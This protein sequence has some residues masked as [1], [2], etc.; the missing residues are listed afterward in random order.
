MLTSVAQDLNRSF[1]HGRNLILE[2]LPLLFRKLLSVIKG[3]LIIAAVSLTTG[4]LSYASHSGAECYLKGHRIYVPDG[5]NYPRQAWAGWGITC[6][7]ATPEMQRDQDQ[8]ERTL[9]SGRLSG[10]AG[11]CGNTLEDA[12]VLSSMWLATG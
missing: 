10:A 2:C 8:L 11:G 12:T 1:P 9:A 4:N 7:T 6:R 3:I 5:L